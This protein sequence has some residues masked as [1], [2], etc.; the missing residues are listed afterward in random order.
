MIELAITLLF[1]TIAVL[2]TASVSACIRNGVAQARAIIAELLM[3]EAETVSVPRLPGFNRP[4]RS[5]STFAPRPASRL[6]AAA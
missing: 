4:A 3:M 5:R 1:V 6:R 2:A